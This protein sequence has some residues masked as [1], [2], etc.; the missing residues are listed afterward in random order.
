[1]SKAAKADAH[2]APAAAGEADGAPA[3]AKKGKK[4]LLLA[5]PVVLLLVGAGG[6][7]SGVLPSLLG[8]GHAAKAE[9]GEAAE[10]G[11]EKHGEAPSDSAMAGPHVPVFTELPLIVA[12]LNTTSKRP[13]F[14]KLT[15]KLE[16]A[17]PEDQAAITAAMP[18]LL[19][20]F[21]TYLRETRPDELQGAAGTWRLRQELIARANIAAAPAR[22]LDVLF[23]ELLVQ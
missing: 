5:I 20:I 14:V 2:A 4:L 6:W 9:H 23:T 21:Q 3:K 18:R 7:F 22:V 1:M 16:I 15:A 10:K 11:G 19:D 13:V 17:K 12:N 8:M